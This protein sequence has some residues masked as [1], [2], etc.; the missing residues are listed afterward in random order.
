MKF[1]ETENLTLEE[2]KEGIT[3]DRG[4]FEKGHTATQLAK[5]IVKHSQSAKAESTLAKDIK[6][7]DLITILLN[8]EEVEQKAAK[9]TAVTKDTKAASNTIIEL[10][11]EIKQSIHDKPL[12]SIVAAQ[13]TKAVNKGLSLF[14]EDALEKMGKAG[15]LLICVA[16]FVDTFFD[17]GKIK[18]GFKK[19]RAAKR[20]A[21]KEQQ[22]KAA[23]VEK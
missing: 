8:G 7:S 10:A 12:N 15:V 6:K 13:G 9:Q 17:L 18:E 2:I 22:E 23:A 14:S 1:K 11:D 20:A 16:V 4:K 3:L 5:L 21:I 19:R